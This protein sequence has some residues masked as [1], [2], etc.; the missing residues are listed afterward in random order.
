MDT[1]YPWILE[2]KPLEAATSHSSNTNRA[3]DDVESDVDDESEEEN[4][5]DQI[6][7]TDVSA[8]K[9]VFEEARNL[10]ITDVPE[11]KAVSTK[12][13]KLQ[14]PGK[15]V[16]LKSIDPNESS[17]T[18]SLTEC[19]KTVKITDK[20]S[21]LSCESS[22]PK[23]KNEDLTQNEVSEITK[24]DA[25]L[26][27]ESSGDLEAFDDDAE[28]L[29]KSSSDPSKLKELRADPEMP[30]LAIVGQRLFRF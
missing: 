15:P 28:A 12:A 10:A 21:K 2:C 5:A 8:V 19:F 27:Q 13:T 20:A 25:I 7:D 23:V 3:V 16:D 4:T 30:S 6:V 14:E 18:E 1:I 17:V 26:L 22:K 29:D 24:E 9:A 11:Y